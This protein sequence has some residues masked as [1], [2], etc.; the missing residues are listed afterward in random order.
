VEGGTVA[1][2]EELLAVVG[3][4][5]K[6]RAV[7]ALVAADGLV[8][9]TDPDLEEGEPV[10]SYLASPAAG[11]QL[12]HHSGRV[13]T[14]FVYAEPDEGFAAFPG[15]LPGG[16]P[17]GA[18]RSE[19]RAQFGVPER[20]GEA[21]TRPVVGRQGSWDRFAVGQLRIHFGYTEVGEHVRRV[22]V[23]AAADAP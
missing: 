14:A 11:Y 21:V 17:R 23:M 2:A 12:M 8:A 3:T 6:S 10:R 4:P 22:T 19:V 20:S 16:L 13:A 15:P 18:T 7:R 9:S 5:V 1:T